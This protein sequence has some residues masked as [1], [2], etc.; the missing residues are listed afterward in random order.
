[1]KNEVVNC[2]WS[3]VNDECGSLIFAGC[4]FS[5]LFLVTGICSLWYIVAACPD[6]SESRSC[7]VVILFSCRLLTASLFSFLNLNF[8]E[9]FTIDY[10]PFTIQKFL[11]CLSHDTDY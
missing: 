8:F 11:T 2:E 6:C 7:T 4:D 1:M 10:S 3:I 5:F 9:L